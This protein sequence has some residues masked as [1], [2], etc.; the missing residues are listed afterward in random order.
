MDCVHFLGGSQM[1][2]VVVYENDP[3]LKGLNEKES[4]NYMP[5]RDMSAIP[6][7]WH[8]EYLRNSIEEHKQ[9]VR[10]MERA[11]EAERRIREENELYAQRIE[12]AK[13]LGKKAFDSRSNVDAAQVDAV[14]MPSEVYCPA[15][16]KTVGT[17][18]TTNE[19]AAFVRCSQCYRLVKVLY[20]DGDVSEVVIPE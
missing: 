13:Q 19:F 18:G 15:C 10:V 7:A 6:I 3:M 8:E 20:A 12:R 2:F 4:R 9:R 5:I 17:E 11:I 1:P 16:G 14:V